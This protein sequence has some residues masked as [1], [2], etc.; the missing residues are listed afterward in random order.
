DG[1]RWGLRVEYAEESTPLSTVGPLFGLRQRL[2]EHFLVMNG[3]VLTDLH[4]GQLL[5]RHRGGGAPLTVAT[6]PRT[7]RVDFGVLEVR[8]ERNVGFT[9]KPSYTHRVS[10][11]VYGMSRTTLDPY[12]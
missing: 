10:M 3:D 5:M 6:F 8:E 9:E 11:G 1:S 4:F 12:P 2:P 7:T